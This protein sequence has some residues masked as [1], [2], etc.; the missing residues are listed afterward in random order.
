MLLGKRAI[1]K[2]LY[3]AMLWV[4]SCY[5]LCSSFF[6]FPMHFLQ[7]KFAKH[8]QIGLLHSQKIRENGKY[9][10]TPFVVE[11]IRHYSF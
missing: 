2:A 6:Y 5:S 11:L 9:P 10:S 1:Q 3:T 7:V 8:G 4:R